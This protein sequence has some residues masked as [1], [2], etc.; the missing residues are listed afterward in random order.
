MFASLFS[1]PIIIA[2]ILNFI[3]YLCWDIGVR[4]GNVVSL[5]LLADFI[6]WLSLT[7]TSIVLGVAIDPMTKLSAAI[8]VIGALTARLGTIER[9]RGG[10]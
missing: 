9:V 5:S 10:P 8:L 7:A 6:P 3:A 1:W 2:G 4:K